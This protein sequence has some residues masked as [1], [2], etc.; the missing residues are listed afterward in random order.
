M[1]TPRVQVV[2]AHPRTASLTA[3]ITAD[4][5]AELHAAGMAVDE[6][7][8]YR[9]PFDPVLREQDEPQWDDLDAQYSETV[10][11]SIAQTREADAVVFVFPVWW[12]S[13][14]A[15]LKGY[16]DRVWN[17]GYFYGGGRR[18][19]VKSILWLGLAGDTDVA[20]AKRNYA[21]MMANHLNVGIA[22]YCG[23]QSSRLELL[24]NTLGDGIEDMP[25]HVAKLRETARVSVRTLAEELP[26]L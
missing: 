17:H 1:T 23:A 25:G 7:D 10:M 8:L 21:D 5:I 3:T 12:Y 14:P 13:F 24:Y 18:I 22:G 2:W 9:I 26:S 16:I 4:V 6:I 20:F 11:A 15:I 19:G